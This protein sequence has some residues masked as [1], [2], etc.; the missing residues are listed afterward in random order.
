MNSTRSEVKKMER[1]EEI[2][3]FVTATAFWFLFAGFL[4]FLLFR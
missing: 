1:W 2:Y 4:V 3:V